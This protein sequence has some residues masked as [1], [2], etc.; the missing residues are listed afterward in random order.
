VRVDLS[1]S[2]AQN[3]GGSGWD[4]LISIENLIG[5][6]WDD[7]LLGNGEDNVIH[8]GAGNDWIDGGGGDDKLFGGSNSLGGDTIAYDNAVSGVTLSLANS[9]AQT[10]GGA[11]IDTITE[12]EN[13]RGSRFNDVLIGSAAANRIEGGEGNDFVW[14]SAGRDHQSGGAG[15]DHFLYRNAS[16]AGNGSRK[17]DVITDFEAIDRINLSRMDANNS[18][19]GNQAFVWI[20]SA[21]F[22]APGQLR[23][24]V[25]KGNGLLE[26]NVKG[27]SGAEFQIEILGGFALQPGIHVVL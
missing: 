15:A 10:T 24:T 14:G 27:S 1:I 17:R 4:T 3:T 5:S 7:V 20:G 13:L 8:G 21:A 2:T 9:S 16:E 6:T 12:F 23:Y 22:S 11:G 19:S 25:A 26:G 18:V